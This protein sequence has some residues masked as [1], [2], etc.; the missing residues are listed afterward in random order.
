MLVSFSNET[1]P[2]SIPTHSLIPHS[3][4]FVWRIITSYPVY[5]NQKSVVNDG[6]LQWYMLIHGVILN[7]ILASANNFTYL[8]FHTSVLLRVFAAI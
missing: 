2:K 8:R 5:F 3:Y 7:L 4:G 1:S 6:N